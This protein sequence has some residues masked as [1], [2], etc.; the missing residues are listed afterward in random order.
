[1]YINIAS[2]VFSRVSDRQVRGSYNLDMGWI[3]LRHDH[4]ETKTERRKTHGRWVKI[5]SDKGTIYRIIRYSGSLERDNIVIDYLGWIEL[6][7]REDEIEVSYPVTISSL[8]WYE[9]LNP[10]FKH[11]DPGIRLS[12]Y[13]AFGLGGLSVTLGI[14][15][16]YLGILS[17]PK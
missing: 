16:I 17:L 2:R 4:L 13:L 8:E 3:V 1:M 6:Q 14:V 12:T 10:L 5:K 15:S 9:Y 7:G 11:I